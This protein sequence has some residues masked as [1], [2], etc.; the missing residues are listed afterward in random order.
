M[1]VT[2]ANTPLGGHEQSWR[3]CHPWGPPAP[4]A[5]D[6]RAEGRRQQPPSARDPSAGCRA[7]SAPEILQHSAWCCTSVRASVADTDLRGGGGGAGFGSVASRRRPSSTLSLLAPGELGARTS[8]VQ[9][10][11]ALVRLSQ[12]LP[13][14]ASLQAPWRPPSHSR[15]VRASV[16]PGVSSPDEGPQRQVPCRHHCREHKVSYRS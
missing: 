7:Q 8:S 11:S 10:S 4:N 15:S 16:E 1:V 14:L 9:T 5:H 6:R 2:V 13:L 3:P 12:P